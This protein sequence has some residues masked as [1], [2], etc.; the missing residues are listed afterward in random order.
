MLNRL[1][2]VFLMTMLIASC[3][4][5]GSDREPPVRI[6]DL[7]CTWTAPIYLTGHDID[8][9]DRQTKKDILLHNELW[10]ANCE[11]SGDSVLS[12]QPEGKNNENYS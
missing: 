2:I 12:I 5:N 11:Q 7:G 10:Q 9:L 6:I 1:L 8:V 4:T 3:G